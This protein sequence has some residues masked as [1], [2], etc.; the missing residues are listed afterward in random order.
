MS[1]NDIINPNIK[2]LN[3]NNY[4]K[5]ISTGFIEKDTIILIEYPKIYLSNNSKSNDDVLLNML[6]LILKYKDSLFIQNLYP[7]A[8]IKNPI[9][10]INN[11]YNINL[12]K[13]I[14]NCTNK[15][16]KNYLLFFDKDT[17][18]MHYYKYL[19]N[20]F[21]MNNSPVILPIG[22]MM[23]HSNNPNIM[24]YPENNRMVFKTTKKIKPNEELCYSYLR[25]CKYTTNEEINE[26]LYNHYNITPQVNY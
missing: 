2:I 4:Y 5:I 21:D 15:V 25:N 20:A 26:Y 11:P 19:C 17:L 18:Y 6:Y 24:F 14:K 16:I 3:D 1:Y 8:I 22:A 7:R 23:N 9:G 12:N 10:N 13:L